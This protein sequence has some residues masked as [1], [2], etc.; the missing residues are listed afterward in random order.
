MLH[1][2]RLPQR[3]ATG[4]AALFCLGFT[5]NLLPHRI[6]FVAGCL[7][8]LSMLL[9]FALEMNIGQS[10]HEADLERKTRRFGTLTQ[11]S[12]LVFFFGVLGYMRER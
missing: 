11:F 6:P 7:F 2:P 10:E 1:H 8:T 9:R 3:L 5:P 4:G 12:V